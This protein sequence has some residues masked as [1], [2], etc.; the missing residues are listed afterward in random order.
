MWMMGFISLIMLPLMLT[1]ASYEENGH[2]YNLHNFSLASMGD[3][4]AVC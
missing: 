3:A 1:L 2:S 4:Q